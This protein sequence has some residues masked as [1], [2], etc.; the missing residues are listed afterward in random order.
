M[1]EGAILATLEEC[2]YSGVS[3][4]LVTPL[5]K[6]PFPGRGQPIEV[7]QPAFRST[8]PRNPPILKAIFEDDAMAVHPSIPLL[9][10]DLNARFHRHEMTVTEVA[11]Q[12]GNALMSL[13][14][15]EDF[16]DSGQ[17]VFDVLGHP[18]GALSRFQAVLRDKGLDTASIDRFNGWAN[19]FFEDRL[20]GALEQAMGLS[21]KAFRTITAPD[22]RRPVDPFEPLDPNDPAMQ[23]LVQHNI[24]L[25]RKRR[26]P[27][28]DSSAVDAFVQK[29][30]VLVRDLPFSN[31]AIRQAQQA[32][33]DYYSLQIRVALDQEGCLLQSHNISRQA[34]SGLEAGGKEA[35]KKYPEHRTP[36]RLADFSAI[37]TGLRDNAQIHSPFPPTVP[38]GPRTR[39]SR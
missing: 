38:S 14:H 6:N 17:Y 8:P 31:D 19:E 12:L 7:R 23:A 36:R 24:E 30:A 3:G 2:V 26:Q 29:V 18:S 33:T 22:R 39:L 34:L 20:Q 5:M 25:V 9:T 21:Q 32:L 11:R 37:F 4:R 16:S 13:P 35:L 10:Q 28:E 15:P 27:N 1:K